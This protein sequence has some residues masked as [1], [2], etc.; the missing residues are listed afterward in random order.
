M[1]P[2]NFENEVGEAG[3]NMPMYGH[4]HMKNKHGCI[5]LQAHT[6][7]LILNTH[8]QTHMHMYAH[9]YIHLKHTCMHTYGN[10]HTHGNLHKY[11]CMHTC[12]HSCTHTCARTHTHTCKHTRMCTHTSL[13]AGE[14]STS[15]QIPD[16]MLEQAH[17][18]WGL[19]CSSLA[20]S[21]EVRLVLAY[22]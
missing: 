9:T 10:T 1:K 21:L 8:M 5:H 22:L 19:V 3:T 4:T 18:F 11:T 17:A 13:S 14:F 15:S 20:P 16:T 6:Y 12:K 2:A 7:T